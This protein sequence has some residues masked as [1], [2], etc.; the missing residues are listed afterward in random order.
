M[1]TAELSTES[2]NKNINTYLIKRDNII[3]QIVALEQDIKQMK[4]K[5]HNI[6]LLL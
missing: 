1:N 6:E 3:K 4:Q 2:T 5:K